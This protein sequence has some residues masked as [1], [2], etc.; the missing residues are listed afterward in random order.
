MNGSAINRVK[1]IAA[2]AK[3]SLTLEELTPEKSVLGGRIVRD[4]QEIFVNFVR[5]TPDSEY[6]AY[7]LDSDGLPR[8]LYPDSTPAGFTMQNR[9][10]EIIHNVELL[11]ERRLKF[12]MTRSL[13]GKV[14]G[15]IP[16]QIDGNERRVRQ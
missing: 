2:K 4:N 5:E 14:G 1:E 8:E 12:H 9:S 11:L 10:D 7:G 6:F 16:M 13:V 15:Y 3:A